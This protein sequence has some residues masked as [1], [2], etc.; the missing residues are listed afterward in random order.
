MKMAAY[1]NLEELYPVN[2]K[3]WKVYFMNNHYFWEG[4]LMKAQ[5]SHSNILNH[6][7]LS[8]LQDSS[9]ILQ[10]ISSVPLSFWLS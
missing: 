7:I 3:Q 1:K 4:L 6:T 5:S 10:H 8:Q 9:P 2:L